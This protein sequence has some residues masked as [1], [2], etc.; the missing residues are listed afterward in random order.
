MVWE[1]LPCKVHPDKNDPFCDGGIP[2]RQ[3]KLGM[4][5]SSNITYLRLNIFDGDS[6]NTRPSQKL[7]FSV[8]VRGVIVKEDSLFVGVDELGKP[9]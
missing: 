4:P 8:L 9:W 7:V 6:V 2:I 3:L 1:Q 5:C